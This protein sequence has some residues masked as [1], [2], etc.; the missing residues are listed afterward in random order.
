MAYA[1][2]AALC[3]AMSSHFR[4]VMNRAPA[5][6]IQ[7]VLRTIG[8]LMLGLLFVFCVKV[9]GWS[10]G[11]V[12]GFGMLSAAALLIVFILPYAPRLIVFGGAVTLVP[13]LAGLILVMNG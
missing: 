13:G 12:A 9:W 5:Q 6:K 10:I 2:M 8:W 11:I 3:L 7:F 1:G 4:Q